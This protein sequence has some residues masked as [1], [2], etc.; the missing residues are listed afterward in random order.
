MRG[1]GGASD[2]P[3]VD[4]SGVAVRNVAWEL[5]LDS[6][7]AEVAGELERRGVQSLLLKGPALARWLYD[8][9]TARSYADIDLLIAPDQ[10]GTAR[11]CLGELGFDRY[12]TG[13]H[14]H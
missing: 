1:R 3:R 12:G 2:G 4:R 7:L 8:E 9:V 6:A 10:F 11:A 13:L 5:A 14:P